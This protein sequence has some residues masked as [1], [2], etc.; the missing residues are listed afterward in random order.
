MTMSK[1]F[2]YGSELHVV[3]RLASICLIY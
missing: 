2:I 1:P 3:R